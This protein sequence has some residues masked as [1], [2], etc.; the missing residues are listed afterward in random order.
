[1][2]IIAGRPRAP[3]TGVEFDGSA[4]FA[5]AAARDIPYFFPHQRRPSVSNPAN[6]V[7]LPEGYARNARS[8]FTALPAGES[9]QLTLQSHFI[10]NK[11]FANLQADQFEEFLSNREEAI[12]GA[13]RVFLSKF[14]L[15]LDSKAERN[16]E[17]IDTDE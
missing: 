3:L 13:E 14:D 4:V 16:Q 2:Q 8:V 15:D 9:T 12:L 10:S 11:P 17:E 7:I 6:R 1:M 5:D